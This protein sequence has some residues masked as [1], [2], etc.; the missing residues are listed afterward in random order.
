M[1]YAVTN[2]LHPQRNPHCDKLHDFNDKHELP[3]ELLAKIEDF[4]NYVSAFATKKADTTSEE[5]ASAAPHNTDLT[6]PQK[7]APVGVHMGSWPLIT[8]GKSTAFTEWKV[9]RCKPYGRITRRPILE[10]PGSRCLNPLSRL[11]SPLSTK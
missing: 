6:F 2:P 9:A 10:N 1:S 5:Y 8:R 4:N 7:A 11:N 3:E